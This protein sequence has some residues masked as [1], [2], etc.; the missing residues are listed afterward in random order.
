MKKLMLMI[1]ILVIS[2]NAFACLGPSRSVRGANNTAC[3]GASYA[4][5]GDT[6]V[7][8]FSVELENPSKGTTIVVIQITTDDKCYTKTVEF[9]NGECWKPISIKVNRRECGKVSIINAYVR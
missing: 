2:L 4:C 3:A 6:G 8:E 1:S 9:S 5:G 7:I